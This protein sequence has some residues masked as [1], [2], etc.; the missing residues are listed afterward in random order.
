MANFP[1]ELTHGLCPKIAIFPTFF[2]DNKGQENVFY[3]ILGRKIAFLG[4]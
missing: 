4:Y 3:N 1:K 2:L